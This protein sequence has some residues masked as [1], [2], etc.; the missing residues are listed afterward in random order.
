MRPPPP[1]TVLPGGGLCNRMSLL[2]SALALGRRLGRPVRLLWLRRPELNAPFEDLF[3]PI[4][5]LAHVENLRAFGRWGHLRLRVR[6]RLARLLGTEVWG[7]RFTQDLSADRAALLERARAAG[8]LLVRGD[9]RVFEDGPL[10]QGFAPERR[11][12][13]RIAALEP[14]LREAV[15][16]HVRRTDNA[17]STRESPLSAFLEAMHAER[18]ARPGCRFFLST[19]A[20]D[21]RAELQRELGD[22]VF[23]HPHGTFDRNDP[24]AIAEAVVDLFSLGACGSL[25]GSHAST[26]STAAH[27]LRGIPHRIV[28][29]AA[30]TEPYRAPAPARG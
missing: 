18:A 30:P 16:V 22:A 27:Q 6:N 24:Q 12:A 1:I 23:H 10:F 3:E 25:I 8:A 13:A 7:H 19:D 28:R 5:G 15:G 20:P 9:G 2:D 17:A 11:L 14:L 4:P 21:V 26:F 29:V